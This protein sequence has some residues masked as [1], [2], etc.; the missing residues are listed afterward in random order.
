MTDGGQ[1]AASL[2][3]RPG[4]QAM[5]LSNYTIS[6][7]AT[8]E[9]VT[10]TGHEMAG[11]YAYAGL[12]MLVDLARYVSLD[13]FARSELYKGFIDT[14]LA[15]VI[16]E[17]HAQYGRNEKLLDCEQRKM[18]FTPLFYDSRGDFV[19]YRDGLISAAA[20]FSEW[21]QAT[22][23][24]M[25]REAVRTMHRPFKQHLNLFSG[26][27]VAW[28]RNDALPHLTEEVSYR[29]LRERGVTSVFSVF[30]A[31]DPTWPY[32]EDSNGDQVVEE[33]SK[34]LEPDKNPPLT[35]HSFSLQQRAALRGAEAIAAVLDYAPHDNDEDDL[36]VLITKCYTWYAALRGITGMANA[37]A[38]SSPSILNQ[39]RPAIAAAGS[40][41]P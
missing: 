36:A 9:A 27:S 17:L 23:I 2:N 30:T 15:S 41:R 33:I 6:D 18:V 16:A 1:P 13:F 22:G 28:S 3:A 10:G 35:R 4:A 7:A 20:T 40:S 39:E 5:A 11:L 19:R 26:L 34:R 24:P 14:T 21:S 38:D 8:F 29:I 12:D 31:P 37:I 32:V 25:L